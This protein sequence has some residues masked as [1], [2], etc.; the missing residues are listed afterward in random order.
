MATDKA[1]SESQELNP[2]LQKVLAPGAD[3]VSI[4]RSF[5]GPAE[6]DGDIRPCASVADIS[7]SDLF[8]ATDRLRSGTGCRP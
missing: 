6:R 7:V 4:L 5:I 3:N 8:L 2:H 1:S